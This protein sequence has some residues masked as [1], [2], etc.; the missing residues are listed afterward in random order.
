MNK[1]QDKI[2]ALYTRL[3]R[4]DELYGDSSSIQTQK[5]MLLQY[6]KQNG[7]AATEY[8]VDD[9]Y[10]G[11]NFKRPD[12]TRLKEDIER[13]V[14][15]TVIV[16][17]LSRFGRDYLQ[18]GLYT[19]NF[20]PDNDVRFIAIEDNV[21]SD[22]GDNEFAPFK[23]IMNEWYARDVS[24]K[25]RGGIRIKTQQGLYMGSFAPYGYQKDPNN[26]HKLIPDERTAPIVKLIFQMASTGKS[27]YKIARHLQA[28]Q[29]KTP[30]E[31]LM[32][33]GLFADAAPY[34]FS[35]GD[36]VVYRL[37]KN[38]VY[39]GHMVGQK[40][41]PKSYKNK[42]RIHRPADVWIE[43]KN[44]HEPLV[45]EDLFELVQKEIRVKRVYRKSD[46]VNVFAGKVFC[47]DCGKSMNISSAI[48][49]KHALTCSTYKR[50]GKEYCGM[51]Y[52]HYKTLYD[53]VLTRIRQMASDVCNDTG[54][55]V[56]ELEKSMGK[57]AD[58]ERRQLTKSVMNSERRISEI[59]AI[60]KKLYEDNVLGKISDER[61]TLLSGEYEQEQK[62]LQT[63]VAAEKKALTAMTESQTGAAKFLSVIQRCKDLTE[64]NESIVIELVDKIVVHDGVWDDGSTVQSNGSR[65]GQGV[66][67]QQIDIYYNFVGAVQNAVSETHAQNQFTF[68][69]SSP[70]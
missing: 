70:Q 59:H 25:V 8:Y 57:S 17:D 20:F 39:I 28:L 23:N 6:A 46:F 1:Q 11:T 54:Y 49:G 16:K 31:V 44:T 2:T 29:I 19:E 42:K 13:G 14:V 65:A 67:K 56:R 48:Q 38:R 40:S 10:T 24:K 18:V 15:G 64:L 3:S 53:V 43:V 60:I 51:H 4:D 58:S 7:F 22:K 63:Q 47:P 27:P 36:T 45:D 33:R 21:D 62:T 9:G 66:R 52:I 37:L 69:Y 30:R 12:F 5:A 35:W 55:F 26:K 68:S 50:Y 34:P 41:T 61:F 32:E